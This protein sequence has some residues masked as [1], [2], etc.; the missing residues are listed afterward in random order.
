MRQICSME[1]CTKFVQ[2]KGVCWKHGAKRV[3]KKCSFVGCDK[4]AQTKKGGNGG[5]YCLKHT[6]K[7]SDDGS[8]TSS[9]SSVE[10]DGNAGVAIQA[11]LSLKSVS[12]LEE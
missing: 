4:F 8:T 10:E 5:A 6:S 2:S 12:S 1:G 9:S 11:L 3:A 7:S